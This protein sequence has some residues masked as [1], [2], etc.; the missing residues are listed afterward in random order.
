MPVQAASEV[1]LTVH[2]DVPR[3]EFL[4]QPN[5]HRH[6][7]YAVS[8][9]LSQEGCALY[10]SLELHSPSNGCGT[11]RICVRLR[12]LTGPADYRAGCDFDFTDCACGELVISGSFVSSS[13]LQAL[14]S[15]LGLWKMSHCPWSAQLPVPFH[16]E[17]R[18][19]SSKYNCE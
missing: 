2:Q 10:S 13:G 11:V 6:T 18:C 5:L 14:R 12:L 1:P 19:H 7:R 9:R 4:S 8:C 17:K 3:P 16:P 15:E